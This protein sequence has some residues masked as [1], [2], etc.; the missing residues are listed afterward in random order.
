VEELSPLKGPEYQE[1]ALNN[2]LLQNAGHGLK[3]EFVQGKNIMKAKQFIKAYT[4]LQ[5]VLE[6]ENIGE[7]ILFSK[8]EQK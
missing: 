4:A 7:S 3:I 6:A 5:V 8:K 2:L 1:E